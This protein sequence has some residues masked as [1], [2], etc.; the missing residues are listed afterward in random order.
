LRLAAIVETY[1]L[2]APETYGLRL[3]VRANA[4]TGEVTVIKGLIP[5]GVASLDDTIRG[6]LASVEGVRTVR[7]EGSG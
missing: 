1:L 2:H 4:L 7:V 3:G 5:G 6:I